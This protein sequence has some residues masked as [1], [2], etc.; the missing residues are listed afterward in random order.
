MDFAARRAYT[1]SCC[2]QVSDYLIPWVELRRLNHSSRLPS[3]GRWERLRP[4]H[5]KHRWLRTLSRIK[6]ELIDIGTLHLLLHDLSMHLSRHLGLHWLLHLL[7]LYL[8]LLILAQCFLSINILQHSLLAFLHLNR[9][10][11]LF[12]CLLRKLLGVL[13]ATR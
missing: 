10:V 4:R 13:S 6:L 5:S 12:R 8:L 3:G 11:P 9:F 7:L 2:C 1:L